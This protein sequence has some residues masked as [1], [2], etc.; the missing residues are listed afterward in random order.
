MPTS[1]LLVCL[2]WL[3]QVSAT[4]HPSSDKQNANKIWIR[5]PWILAEFSEKKK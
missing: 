2:I 3:V 5:K 1:S 4:K